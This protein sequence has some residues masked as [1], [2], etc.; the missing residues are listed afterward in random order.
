MTPIAINIQDLVLEG[1][2]ID[3]EGAI[4]IQTLDAFGRTL[5][6]YSWIDWGGDDVGWMNDDFEKVDVTFQTGQGLWNPKQDTVAGP[7]SFLFASHIPD[8]ELTR[9]ATWRC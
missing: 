9:P 7:S 1:D 6:T 3:T 4:Y 8:L 2:E 5:E